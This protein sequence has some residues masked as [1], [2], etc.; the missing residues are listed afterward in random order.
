MPVLPLLSLLLAPAPSQELTLSIADL[1]QPSV[2]I[3]DAYTPWKGAALRASAPSCEPAI[4]ESPA[5]PGKPALSLKN[6]SFTQDPPLR[7]TGPAGAVL[8]VKLAAPAACAMK[9]R[10]M[11][12]KLVLDKTPPSPFTGD[13]FRLDKSGHPA[14]KIEV[15]G[16]KVTASA[17]KDSA[18]LWATTGPPGSGGLCEVDVAALTQPV[19]EVAGGELGAIPDLGEARTD[20]DGFCWMNPG[21]AQSGAEETA[22]KEFRRERE[23]MRLR[24]ETV[25]VWTNGQ[26]KFVTVHRPRHLLPGQRLRFVLRMPEKLTI[27]ARQDGTIGYSPELDDQHATEAAALVNPTKRASETADA[28]HARVTTQIWEFEGRGPGLAPIILE[29]EPGK[30]EHRVEINYPKTYLGSVRLGF[31]LIGGRA[32]APEYTGAKHPGSATHEVVERKEGGLGWELVLGYSVYPEAMLGG[33]NY[34]ERLFS[35]NNWGVGPIVGLGAVSVA[36]GKVE[37][38][39]SLYLGLEF[40]PVRFFSISAGPVFRRVDVLADGYK[41]GSALP[42]ATVPTKERFEIGWFVMINVAPRFMKTAFPGK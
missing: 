19:D 39:K 9:L 6:C 33:R 26:G 31:S 23:R 30:E 15:V 11:N 2:C 32:V 14:P 42:D 25:C 37:L 13:L 5:C 18:K 21:E 17:L 3:D 27:R 1:A 8:T 41:V 7:I 22:L 34:R 16:G 28:A 29:K 24:R 4:T 12:E 36:S 35:R 40:E 38:F 10:F 20:L